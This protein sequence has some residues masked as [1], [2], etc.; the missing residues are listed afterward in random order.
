MTGFDSMTVYKLI[1]LIVLY[2][3]LPLTALTYY[4]FR[5][6]RRESEVEHIFS[7]AKIDSTYRRAYEEEKPGRYFLGAV[8]YASAVSCIGLS[9]LFLGK[10][11]GMPEFPVVRLGGEGGVDFP[12]K[13]SRLVCGMAILGAYLWGLQYIFRRYSLNDL[14]PGVYYGLSVRI[15]LAAIITLV[16]Y[17]AYEALAGG[18][19]SGAGIT[20]NIWPALALLLGMFPQRGLRWLTGRLPIFSGDTDPSVRSAP[21]EMIEGITVHDTIRLGEAGID[22]CYDLAAADFVPLILR[23]PYGAR[24]LVDWILQAKLCVYFGGA[25]KELRQHSI[26]TVIDLEHLTSDDIETLATGTV[27]TKSALERAHKSVQGDAEIARLRKAG[28]LL[29]EFI[30]NADKPTVPPV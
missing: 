10:D 4:L 11:I 24:Q 1:V 12:Q 14:I 18:G 13:G 15:I 20:E 27:L 2:L 17:N 7:I 16:I 3:F 8:V 30:K 29:G 26:R 9:L 6:Y 5:R 19:D 22:T 23:T 25:V 21:L 28:Q